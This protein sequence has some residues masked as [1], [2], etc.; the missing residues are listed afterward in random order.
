MILDFLLVLARKLW[1]NYLIWNNPTKRGG[2]SSSQKLLKKTNKQTKQKQ[3]QK[4]KQTIILPYWFIVFRKK[5]NNKRYWIARNHLSWH[6]L[7]LQMLQKWL[8]ENM[9]MHVAQ[10][11]QEKYWQSSWVF[12]F[13]HT[14]IRTRAKMSD[15]LH[16]HYTLLTLVPPGWGVGL[17]LPVPVRRVSP[18]LPI[19]QAPQ[20]SSPLFPEVKINELQLKDKK[21]QSSL[22]RT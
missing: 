22:W 8:E 5:K 9:E 7:N 11:S 16:N 12:L 3:K 18:L 13:R 21:L 19:Q 15:V 14:I 4:Q 10:N 1:L 17:D 2:R 6:S 20:Q